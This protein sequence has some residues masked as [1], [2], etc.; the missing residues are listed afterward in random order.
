MKEETMAKEMEVAMNGPELVEAD[1]LLKESMERY[2]NG[3]KW[4]FIKK[5]D[6]KDFLKKSESKVIKRL[7]KDK[8]KLSFT[9]I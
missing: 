8:S 5:E 9:K 3:G 2:W 6:I 7:M 1:G 4:H